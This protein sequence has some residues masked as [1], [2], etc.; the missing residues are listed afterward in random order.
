MVSRET[1]WTHFF[2]LLTAVFAYFQ[3]A[4]GMHPMKYDAMD[5]FLP[6]RFSVS[7]SFQAG[8]L[9]LW[10]PYQDFGYPMQADPSSGAWYPIAWVFGKVWGYSVHVISAE[11]MLYVY[12]AGWGMM[13][14]CKNLGIAHRGAVLAGIAFMAGGMFTGNAQHMPY[15]AGACW[16]VWFLGSYF[17]AMSKCGKW[18]HALQGGFFLFLLVSGGYPAFTVILAYLLILFSLYF[19]LNYLIRKNW[20]ELGRTV[21]FSLVMCLSCLIFSSGMLYSLYEVGPYLHRLG[22]FSLAQAQFSPF[23]FQSFIS[24]IFPLATTLKDEAWFGTDLAMRNGYL[25]IFPLILFLLALPRKKDVKLWILLLFGF[26]CLL[27]AVGPALPLREWLFQHVPGMNIFRFP[28]VFRLFFMISA[29]ITAAWFADNF[30]GKAKQ[31]ILIALFT[32]AI[33]ILITLIFLRTNQY[34]N[35]ALYFK[36]SLF[37]PEAPQSFAQAIGVQGALHLIL[38]SLLIVS[39]LRIRSSRSLFLAITFICI[40]DLVMSAQL[41]GPYTVY[42]PQVTA[43]QARENLSVYP[44]GFPIPPHISFD[45]AAK[46]PSPGLPF[47]INLAT[48]Q[49]VLSP[50]GYNS[51]T[52]SGLEILE[53]DFPDLL[54]NIRK[55]KYLTLSASVFPESAMGL[56]RKNETFEPNHIFLNKN[57]FESLSGLNMSTSVS[58]KIEMTDF[59]ALHAVLNIE[60]RDPQIATYY[61]RYYTGWHAYLNGNEVP[62]LLS[63]L[64]FMSV[65]IPSGNSKLEFRYKNPHL[66]FG[67]YFSGGAILLYLMLILLNY[68]LQLRK[69]RIERRRQEVWTGNWLNQVSD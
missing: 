41:N 69:T 3:V 55:N 19:G 52:F 2:L 18:M 12:L 40:A 42:F 50:E 51:F 67:F 64:N 9:P 38:I 54:S 53:R 23:T 8:H 15:A 20:Q 5:C 30:L 34:L 6:W 14:L 11:F 31:H 43:N 26:L 32:V 33:G 39:M 27:A 22:D 28:S 57:D 44:K 56:M 24:F 29:I 16:L 49:K 60:S 58:D 7:E 36:E 66:E 59:G 65:L 25:G 10:N 68:I 21:F 62:I 4:T 37:S 45:E 35:S 1:G 13:Y 61:Q 48:F 47:W 63:N 17:K 46:Q